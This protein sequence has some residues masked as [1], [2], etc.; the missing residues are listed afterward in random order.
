MFTPSGAEA[1]R[2]RIEGS[3]EKSNRNTAEIRNPYN[4]HKTQDITFSNRNKKHL[5][6]ITAYETPT[7]AASHKS[8]LTNH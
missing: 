2:L 5:S 3:E 4:L 6:A 7:H 1:T 8:Q